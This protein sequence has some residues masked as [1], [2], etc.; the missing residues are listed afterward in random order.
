MEPKRLMATGMRAPPPV[1]EQ[2]VLEQQRGPAARALHAAIG[3]LGHLQARAH[4]MRD[5]D[6]LAARLDGAGGTPGG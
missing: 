5:A 3:D 1:L 2:H 6:Q 4:R